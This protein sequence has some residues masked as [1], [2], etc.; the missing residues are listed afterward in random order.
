MSKIIK[1]AFSVSVS[2]FFSRTLIFLKDVIVASKLGTGPINDAFVASFKLISIMKNF[3]SENT[4]NII[5][6][7]YFSVL[8]H[9]ECPKKAM[10]FANQAYTSLLILVSVFVVAVLIFMPQV[11]W[12]T[13]STFREN[14]TSYFFS[15]LFGRVFLLYLFLISIVAF[16]GGMMNSFG[17]FFPYATAPC[18]LNICVILSLLCFN[19]CIT[20]A[21]TICIATSLGAILELLWILFFAKKSDCFPKLR[22]SLRKIN[23]KKNFPTLLSSIVIQLNNSINMI[24]LSFFGG[25]ISYLYYAERVIQL[26]FSLIGTSVSTVILPSLSKANHEEKNKIYNQAMQYIFK[27]TTPF[28]CTILSMPQDIIFLLFE[29]DDFGPLNTFHTANILRHFTYGLHALILVK[30]LQNVFF[31]FFN[32]STPTIVVVICIIINFFTALLTISKLSFL[33]IAFSY[34]VSNCVNCTTLFILLNYNLGLKISSS[35]YIQILKFLILSLL[36]AILLNLY[37]FI[38]PFQNVYVL[39]IS[40]II[41]SILLH[42]LFYIKVRYVLQ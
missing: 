18:I 14:E 4:L 28:V 15:I 10:S 27:F 11:I 33:A 42:C 9:N 17:Y 25:G 30:V 38:A 16:Y 34:T 24:L 7:P 35:V 20:T 22:I 19:F 31:S 2:S 36:I 32:S 29:R 26:P 6:T 5:F 41:L 40:K 3:F 21:H 13:I 1:E 37:N 39:I 8:Y 12:Y 23:I